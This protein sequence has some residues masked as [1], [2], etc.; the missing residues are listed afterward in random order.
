MR[1]IDQTIRNPSGLHARPAAMF[2]RAAAGFASRITLE[3]LDRGSAPVDAKSIIA[4]MSSGVAVGHRV[5]VTAEGT[6]EDAAIEALDALI[7]SGLGETL[8]G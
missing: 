7:V 3:N 4:V 2:V 1:T 8:P 5:R 6:D